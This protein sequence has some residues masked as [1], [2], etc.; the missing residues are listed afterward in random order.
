M[1]YTD[2]D[3]ATGALGL[4]IGGAIVQFNKVAV[5]PQLLNMVACP[6]GAES[7]WLRGPTISRRG[8]GRDTIIIKS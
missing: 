2:T 5:M 4:A 8:R 7:A 1:A 6:P 3:V